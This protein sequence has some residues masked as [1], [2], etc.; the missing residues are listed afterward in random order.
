VFAALNDLSALRYLVKK[1]SMGR[2]K[3]PPCPDCGQPLMIQDDDT[4]YTYCRSPLCPVEGLPAGDVVLEDCQPPPGWPRVVM[5]GRPVP[6]ITPVVGDRV[7]WTALNS[8]RLEEAER[9]W[10]CQVCGEGLDVS[11][12]AWVAVAAGEVATGGAMHQ[13][14]LRFARQACPV[15]RRDMSFVYA[16]VQQHD[17]VSDWLAVLERLTQHEALAGALPD[18][19]PFSRNGRT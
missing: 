7:A 19:L 15:L 4:S 17:L 3:F 18:I 2:L 9:L 14:C 5:E 6:W 1:E 13:R 11:L 12:T 16:E 10:L 8:I